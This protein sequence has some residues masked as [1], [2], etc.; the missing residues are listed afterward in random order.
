MAIGGEEEV[1]KGDGRLVAG[2]VGEQKSTCV[3]LTTTI[4]RK[5]QTQCNNNYTHLKYN[6]LQFLF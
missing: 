2:G 5:Y 1:A 3:T 4:N 6:K